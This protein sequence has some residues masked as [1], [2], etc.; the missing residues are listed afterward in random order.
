MGWGGPVQNAEIILNLWYVYDDTGHIYSLRARCYVSAGNDQEKLALL[1][2]FA[3]IDYLIAQPFPIP[4]RFHTTFV[5]GNKPQK[6]PVIHLTSVETFGGP[7]VLFEEA[8]VA[9]ERQLP[10]Q[11]NLS[12]GQRPLVCITPLLAGDK[13]EIRPNFR[14]RSRFDPREPR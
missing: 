7:V 10:A 1:Q 4:E 6:L 9:L 3:Q 2:R 8:F 12:I 13:G 14:S 11:T 5:Q